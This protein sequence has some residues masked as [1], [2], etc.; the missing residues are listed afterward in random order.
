[1]ANGQSSKPVKNLWE[2][3]PLDPPIAAAASPVP[4]TPA[5]RV[6]A[7]AQPAKS[8]WE[9]VPLDMEPP[10]SEPPPKTRSF[11]EDMRGGLE[12]SPDEGVIS[13]SAK[14]IGRG[15]VGLVTSPWEMAKAAFAPPESLEEAM[16]QGQGPAGLLSQRML[17]APAKQSLSE[18]AE[19]WKQG[20]PIR[21]GIHA[22]AAAVPVVG[23]YA[24]ELLGR[25]ESG[26]VAGA[27]SEGATSFG[28]PFVAKGLKA[29]FAKAVERPGNRILKALGGT[30]ERMSKTPEG[31]P[32]VS[33]GSRGDVAQYASSI[34]AD[35][36]PGQA[37][38]AAPLRAIQQVGEKSITGERIQQHVEGQRT[39]VTRAL[40]NLQDRQAPPEDFPSREA[41]GSYYKEQTQ[42]KM[43]ALKKS[44]EADYEQWT[45]ATG[46]TPIDTTPLQ[47][48][49]GAMLGHMETALQNTPA[50]Y[51]GPIRE[52]LGKASKFGKEVL[53]ADVMPET[54]VIDGTKMKTADLSPTL[55]EAALK[56]N[57]PKLVKTIIPKI[58]TSDAGQMRS[59]FWEIA[60]DY[61]GNI[62]ERVNAIASDLVVDLDAEMAKTAKETGTLDIWRAANTKWKALQEA[63]NT[64]KSPL[65]R[66][67]KE[68]DPERVPEQLLVKGNI[69]GSVRSLNIA[70]AAGL[71]LGPARRQ[72]LQ[73]IKE[74][75]FGLGTHGGFRLG[76]YSHDFLS[77]LFG[78]DDLSKLYL[79]GRMA[80][81]IGWRFNPSETGAAV[82]VLQELGGLA[83]LRAQAIAR[84]YG[85]GKFTLSPKIIEATTGVKPRSLR[86]DMAQQGAGGFS[87]RRRTIP[88]AIGANE[89]NRILREMNQ[90]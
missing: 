26:D 23:P 75:N 78:P 2:D 77:N 61:R 12:P 13:R 16:A 14:G 64:A 8:L 25:A 9:D 4:K 80:R 51:S 48:K 46:N 62:P 5:M 53:A 76:G 73:D 81:Q 89:Q 86:A 21:A 56:A 22:A 72:V 83:R 85:A 47:D 42:L 58:S 30:E 54:V 15:L 45:K 17:V 57:P 18:A 68:A 19:S 50:Q 41:I 10:V 38:E 43:E 69:G 36:L 39:A 29:G 35:L 67:L 34:G 59:A 66:I 24:D 74:S 88:A 33:T 87:L 44:A 1:M 60:H 40:E 7:G 27:L 63:Y 55:R 52:I 28:L 70:K 11:L 31:G 3:V 90:R 6:A 32:V 20:H 84:G 37:T 79:Q 49:Y 82:Q 71:D 65:Y